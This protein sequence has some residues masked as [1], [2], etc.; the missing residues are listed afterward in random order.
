MAKFCDSC[1]QGLLDSDRFCQRCGT[2]QP[3]RP[4]RPEADRKLAESVPKPE[5]EAKIGD[6]QTRLAGSVPKEEADTLR[7]R[8][9][10]LESILAVSIPSREAKAELET[11]TRKLRE[12]IEQLKEKLAA[13]H[14]RVKA[15]AEL[16]SK[17]AKLEAKLAE[18]VPRGEVERLHAEIAELE[19][20]L[21]AS[22]FEGDSL[23]MK[24]EQLQDRL[25][26]SVSKA[27]S[28]A[29]VNELEAKLSVE[30][31]ETEVARKTIEDLQGQL[32]ES[33]AKI[34]ELQGKLSDS[35]PRT[36]L[37]T[38][39]TELESKIVNLEAKL[40][41]SVPKNEVDELR[42]GVSVASRPA[43]TLPENDGPSKSCPICEHG[44]RVD[45]IFCAS[46]GH[47]LD[48]QIGKDKKGEM[49][50]IAQSPIEQPST[51][52]PVTTGSSKTDL[53]RLSKLK[54]MV[55]SRFKP[56]KNLIPRPSGVQSG[57]MLE[58][59][60]T[61]LKSLYDSGALTEAEYNQQKT[62]LLG[63]IA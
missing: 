48:S 8:L 51:V 55:G 46:C 4:P 56:K 63:E 58:A 50:P 16:L 44:N 29:R 12:E 53:G 21:A 32:S 61:K 45:A 52:T 28:E 40:A 57:D 31:R 43:Q 42:S 18:S 60:L 22:K 41:L 24:V 11:A 19:K 34:D 39:K 10:E 59:R 5:L 14:P 25:T 1:G 36:E 27:E 9:R 17:I 37:E 62:K 6:L 15:Q 23:R 2:A 33:S 26:E 47:L 49:R 13:P 3:T 7:A 20:K 30:R 35:L 54:S 38:T